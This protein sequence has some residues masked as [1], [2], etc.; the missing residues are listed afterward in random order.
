MTEDLNDL[1]LWAV[2]MG[3][4]CTAI[5]RIVIGRW[6]TPA[7]WYWVA[8]ISCLFSYQYV[9][10]LDMLPAP[11]ELTINVLED[12]HMGAFWGFI[13][14]SVVS[15]LFD[16]HNLSSATR[17]R[18]F[19]FLGTVDLK[20]VDLLLT[21]YLLV[22]LALLGHRIAT[23]GQVDLSFL[24][25]ARESYIGADKSTIRPLLLIL[26][27]SVPLTVLLGTR[28]AT[29]KVKL[30]RPLFFFAICFLTAMAD[31]SRMKLLQVIALGSI[32]VITVMDTERGRRL[33][34]LVKRYWVMTLIGGFSMM[35][36]FQAIQI[37]RSTGSIDLLLSEPLTV[38][39]PTNLMAYLAQGTSAMALFYEAANGP[40]VGGD[41]TFSFPM[42]YGAILGLNEVP[43]SKG[44]VFGHVLRVLDDPRVQRGGISGIGMLLTDFGPDNVWFSSLCMAGALQLIYVACIGRGFIGLTLACCSCMGAL[45]SVL[46]LWFLSAPMMVGMVWS[47]VVA[48]WL[49]IPLWETAPGRPQ[50]VNP[51]QPPLTQS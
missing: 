11:E 6:F 9:L 46:N 28:V 31:A 7:T 2:L 3:V 18:T 30:H 10:G 36:V 27:I 41:L 43:L 19:D 13:G 26:P 20:K 35:V 44:D 1:T 51:R 22:A 45:F 33:H 39:L 34:Q 24:Q 29:G 5:C 12:A 50:Q 15:R 38:L 8:W 14:F 16:V 40:I 32:V 49:N 4:L 47:F 42:K 17:M 23:V 25:A 37:I 48:R 21:F